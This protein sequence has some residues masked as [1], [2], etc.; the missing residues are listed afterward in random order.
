MRRLQRLVRILVDFWKLCHLAPQGHRKHT[1]DMSP[2][3][4][5][6][7]SKAA[8]QNKQTKKKKE[9]EKQAAG[10]S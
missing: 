10:M 4:D 8:K 3:S 5:I 9:Q 7:E 6:T 2:S 1:G